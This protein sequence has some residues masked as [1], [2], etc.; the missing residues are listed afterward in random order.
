MEEGKEGGREGNVS[1]VAQKR[2]QFP[3]RTPSFK[4]LTD[5]STLPPPPTSFLLCQGQAGID[6]HL[7]PMC[8]YLQSLK[9]CKPPDLCQ[10]CL[11]MIWK[12][13]KLLSLLRT[14]C[15]D[16]FKFLCLSSVW[17]LAIRFLTLPHPL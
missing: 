2:D 10:E 3:K 5:S 8:L 11:L 1:Q 16:A 15:L 14:M 17:T 12:V 4:L 6:G 7:F 13:S 9:K